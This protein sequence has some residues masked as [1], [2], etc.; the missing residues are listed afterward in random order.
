MCA[1]MCYVT[2]QIVMVVVIVQRRI[3]MVVVISSDCSSRAAA[4]NVDRSNSLMLTPN[5]SPFEVN[6]MWGESAMLGREQAGSRAGFDGITI[7]PMVPAARRWLDDALVPETVDTVRSSTDTALAP[8][9]RSIT[10]PAPFW[11]CAEKARERAPGAFALVKRMKAARADSRSRRSRTGSRGINGR[12][13][14]GRVAADGRD[15]LRTVS[16]NSDI[17]DSDI[18]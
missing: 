1:V 8:E 14:D 2:C 10:G 9:T 3:V 4:S 16:D 7:G 12:A 6:M 11:W 18:Q 13:L 15:A 17:S 5:L